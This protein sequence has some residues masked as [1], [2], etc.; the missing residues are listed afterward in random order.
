MACNLITKEPTLTV[1]RSGE[2]VTQ[3]MSS[4]SLKQNVAI[5]LKSVIRLGQL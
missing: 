5:N 3:Q 4:V 2:F 1:V